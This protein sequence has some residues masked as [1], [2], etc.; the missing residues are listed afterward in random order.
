MVTVSGYL[1]VFLQVLPFPILKSNSLKIH[2]RSSFVFCQSV[3]KSFNSFSITMKKSI[4]FAIL[5]FLAHQSVT[6]RAHLASTH[7]GGESI[8]IKQLAISSRNHFMIVFFFISH[9]WT[10]FF[11]TFAFWRGAKSNQSAQKVIF[12]KSLFSFPQSSNLVLEA[13]ICPAYNG[14]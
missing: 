4:T 6:Q 5:Q 11:C 14:K 1:S 2:S 7:F 9:P 8:K 13:M 12:Y 3:S 10:L